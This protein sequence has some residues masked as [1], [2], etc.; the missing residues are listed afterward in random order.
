MHSN[1]LQS[2]NYTKKKCNTWKM[3]DLE[4]N[5]TKKPIERN[6]R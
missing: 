5:A 6:E 3:E 1:A 2:G 4:N